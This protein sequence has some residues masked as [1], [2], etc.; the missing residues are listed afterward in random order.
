MEREINQLPHRYC[1]MCLIIKQTWS[2]KTKQYLHRSS[3]YK[4]SSNTCSGVQGWIY[5]LEQN[6]S[7]NCC[8][9]KPSHIFSC[10]T[11]TTTC[12]Q[13]CEEKRS[14]FSSLLTKCLK[15]K[16]FQI[17]LFGL[18]CEHSPLTS[19]FTVFCK[20]LA[21][22]LVNALH[23]PTVFASLFSGPKARGFPIASY[24]SERTFSTTL[25]G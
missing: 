8:A 10:Y 20:V 9:G 22:C 7:R 13:E 12:H 19:A 17:A 6:W 1:L 18:F 25:L 2:K 15:R 16:Y 11:R 23:L 24:S 14:S 5:L 3:F 4:D 21:T